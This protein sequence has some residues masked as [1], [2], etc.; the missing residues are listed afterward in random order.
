MNDNH[1][2]RLFSMRHT[3]AL[4]AAPGKFR[5]GITDFAQAQLGEVIF[6][7][8]LALDDLVQ[9]GEE[10]GEIE[11]AK[12]IQDLFAPI[13]GTVI[14]INDAVIEYPELVNTDPYGSG[15]IVKMAVPANLTHECL[16]HQEYLAA[17]DA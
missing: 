16:T 14:E 6:I 13:T 10:F 15:W 12:V 3:W 4:E 9:A 5:V 2:T 8:V 1:E 11:S 7:E 17:T